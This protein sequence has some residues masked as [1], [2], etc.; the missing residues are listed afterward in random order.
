VALPDIPRFHA[1]GVVASMQPQ[2]AASDG[3]WAPARL[4]PERLAGAYAWRRFLDAGVPIAGGSDFPVEEVAPIDGALYA[5]VARR[6]RSGEFTPDQRM[7][8][9]EAV[10]AF[11][12]TAAYAAFE[13][14]WRGRVAPGFAADLTVL[15]RDVTRD[16]ASALAGARA[17]MTVVAGRVVFER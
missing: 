16:P 3:P 5:A 8:F 7:T 4:G 11:T 6:T 10:R 2:H 12:E 15:D 1:L 13:E 14:G 17:A 9:D